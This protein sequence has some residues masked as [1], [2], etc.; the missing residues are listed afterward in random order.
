[1]VFLCCRACCARNQAAPLELGIFKAFYE[2]AQRGGEIAAR[3]TCMA[4]IGVMEEI[5]RCSR[6]VGRLSLA[7][8][9]LVRVKESAMKMDRGIAH[10]CWP[11]V[12]RRVA[13]RVMPAVSTAAMVAALNFAM[14][15]RGADLGYGPYPPP[16]YGYQPPPYNDGTTAYPPQR[17]LPPREVPYDQR[18]SMYPPPPY[19]PAYPSRRYSSREDL[20][21]EP[22]TYGPP[23][24]YYRGP[25]YPSR[26]YRPDIYEEQ[27][28]GYQGYDPR[29][30]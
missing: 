21:G 4:D 29:G 24:D 11:S 10:S 14:P 25:G 22:Y 5:S 16:P 23:P 1:M 26:H 15:A 2:F 7:F 13:R 27:R 9:A 28:Y 18:R 17:Y 3:H 19:G 6:I 30:F 20:Y 8:S 12:A